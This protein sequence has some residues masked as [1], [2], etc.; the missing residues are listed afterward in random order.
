MKPLHSIFIV[1]DDPIHQ[2]ITQIMLD[3]QHI[4]DAVKKFSDA[5][6]VLEHI[7]EHRDNAAQL[8]DLILLDLN[9][10]VM[11]GYETTRWLRDNYPE[12]H[13]LMLTMYDSEPALIRLLQAG[14]K[15]FLKKDIHPLELKTAIQSVMRSG[16]YSSDSVTRKL[17]NLLRKSGDDNELRKNI[18][19]DTEVRFLQMTCSDMTYKEIAQSLHMSPRAVDMLRDNL[20]TRLDAQS[21]I[22]LAMF[23]IR[24][25]L[26]VL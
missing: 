12:V 20:F 11:D 26:V 2:Q 18:L 7:R 8:P 22:G 1:D 23:A 16:Y 24:S 5:Q 13:V 25:G 6:E 10:P 9:M 4:S 17:I 19:N 3:R 15:G 21:R 14:V